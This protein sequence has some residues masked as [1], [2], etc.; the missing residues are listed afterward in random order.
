VAKG[1]SKSYSIRTRTAFFFAVAFAFLLSLFFVL[2]YFSI[3]DAIRGRSDEEARGQLRAILSAAEDTSHTSLLREAIVHH[4]LIGEARLKFEVFRVDG[5]KLTRVA[6][7]DSSVAADRSILHDSILH[8]VEGSESKTYRQL[9]LNSPHFVG[10]VLVDQAVLEEAQEAMVKQFGILLLLGIVVSAGLGYFVSGISLG[11]MLLLTEA[12]KKIQ[13]P[14]ARK[15]GSEVSGLLPVPKG[16]TE[17]ALLATAVNKLI[18]ERETSIEQLRNF[19][20]DAAHELRTPLTILKGELE[21]EIR[22]SDA[23][24]PSFEVLKSNLEEVERLSAIVDDLLLLA[25]LDQREA[26]SHSNVP[27][28]SI[29]DAIQSV[30]HRVEPL[31]QAKQVTIG[32]LLDGDSTIEAIP[33]RFERMLFNI[34]QNAILYSNADGVVEIELHSNGNPPTIL[35]RDHGIGIDRAALPLIFERF[36]RADKSRSRAAGGSGL[37]LAIAKSIADQSNF[38]L[39]VESELHR[40]TV[41]TI[42]L[43]TP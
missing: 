11:P 37:G 9:V 40:G 2:S 33:E 22:L 28:I 3:R 42:Q 26:E 1:S 38:Q 24:N 35:V 34:I 17:V 25:M 18:E 23:A 7:S 31:A 10:V 29:R 19:T 16:V 4:I 15:D 20:A 39:I 30:I 14:F 6:G 32:E 27:R 43:P 41:V 36:Y 12:A 21:V 5:L 13:S 8:L